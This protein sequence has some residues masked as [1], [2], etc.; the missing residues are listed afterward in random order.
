MKKICLLSP[1]LFLMLHSFSQESSAVF[2]NLGK[3]GM[4]DI[5]TLMQAYFEPYTT[6]MTST[7]SN[8][9][10][11][12]A[13]MH[14]AF[15]FD[16]S[17][18]F[19]MS[20][21]P[22]A[23]QSFNLKDYDLKVLTYTQGVN[24]KSPTISG[25]QMNLLDVGVK[26]DNQLVLDNLFKMPNGAKLDFVGLPMLQFGLG[27]IANTDVQIR[28]LPPLTFSNYGKVF[29]LGGGVKHDVKQ[30]FSKGNK[31]KNTNIA[32][33]LN[34]SIV[35]STFNNFNYFPDAE[36][37][38]IEKQY[39]DNELLK[40]F[41]GSESVV[42]KNIQNDFYNKQEL[43]LKMNA[44]SANIIV[45]QDFPLDKKAFSVATAY[46]SIGFSHSGAAINLKGDYLLPDFEVHNS[47]VIVAIRKE[48]KVSDPV[49]VKIKNTSFRAGIGAR[50]K[51]AAFILHGEIIHQD[52]F[53]YNVGLGISIQ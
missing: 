43:L 1:I 9:W 3:S 25:E 45:S 38:S 35:N 52:Y 46:G 42:A 12:T 50:I 32:V 5:N 17:I 19:A 22:T 16:I 47:D 6:G 34:Y 2:L 31:M 48:N 40:Y 28:T 4:Q 23:S 15:G 53:I 49:D 8:G 18:G 29:I 11:S 41:T 26:I 30:W 20:P 27:L 7:I 51:L 37:L 21:V 36:A 13:K 14:K 44:L 24:P 33:N 39:I 10:F